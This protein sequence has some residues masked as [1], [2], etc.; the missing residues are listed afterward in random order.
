MYDPLYDMV[1]ERQHQIR[2]MVET[3]NSLVEL[4]SSNPGIWQRAAYS[5]GGLLISFGTRMRESAAN[6]RAS[7]VVSGSYRMSEGCR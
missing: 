6:P 2:Q 5:I 3:N 7:R 4:T 1:I